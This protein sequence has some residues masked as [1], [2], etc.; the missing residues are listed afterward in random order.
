MQKIRDWPT[1][2]SVT[3]VRAFLGLA[4]YH[5]A[6]VKNFS[7]IAE[8][9]YRLTKKNCRF[10]WSAE[11]DKAFSDLKNAL[12]TA[13][14]LA[15]PRISQEP[16]TTIDPVLHRNGNLMIV[17]ADASLTAAGCVL[18]QIHDEKRDR[19]RIP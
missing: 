8:P 13:P 12:T 2:L 17:D 3:E 18:S 19:N 15:Y 5:A 10:Q 7:D 1:P 11:A 14:I 6:F 9:L 4:N 16:I